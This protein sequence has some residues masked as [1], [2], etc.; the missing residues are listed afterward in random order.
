MLLFISYYKIL[1]NI[2]NVIKLIM[3]LFMQEYLT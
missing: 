1:Q 2:V 3:F